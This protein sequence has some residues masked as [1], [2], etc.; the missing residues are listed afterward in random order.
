MSRLITIG[1]SLTEYVYP[2]WADMAGTH[3]DEYYNLGSAG[4]GHGYMHVIF[5]EADTILNLQKGDTVM[6]M[7]SSFVRHDVWLPHEGKLGNWGWQGNGNVWQEGKFSKDFFAESYS[8]AHCLMQSYASLKS[9]KEV[10]LSKGINFYLLKGFD[11][12]RLKQD[13]EIVNLEFYIDALENLYT[14]DKKG[15]YSF[16]V[17]RFSNQGFEYNKD[18]G[19]QITGYKYQDRTFPDAHP[20]ITM[21]NSYL[22]AVLP[23]FAISNERM[24]ELE[25]LIKLDNQETNRQI[26]EYNNLRG[27]RIGSLISRQMSSDNMYNFK[28]SV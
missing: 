26:S 5:N 3:F 4:C 15:F 10:C 13:Y 25:S 7:S 18:T 6:V 2:T 23:E 11:T 21:H 22:Q 1:C 8:N 16:L 24:E 27:K 12:N 20:T 28:Y 17:E 19:N 14:I 9:I